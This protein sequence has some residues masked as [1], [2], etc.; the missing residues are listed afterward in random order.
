MHEEASQASAQNTIP[1]KPAITIS[2]Q[3]SRAY[4]ESLSSEKACD[5]GSATVSAWTKFK[6]PALA[7][8]KGMIGYNVLALV[9][10][11]A[12]PAS[13]PTKAMVGDYFWCR[14]LTSATVC[15]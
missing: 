5:G 2:A 4:A 15:D 6:V 11:I 8:A 9:D 7:E 14:M 12:S 3:P 1:H 10:K 13:P